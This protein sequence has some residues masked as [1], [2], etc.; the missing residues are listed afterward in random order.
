MMRY[1]CTKAFSIPECDDDGFI[2]EQEWIVEKG[3]VWELDDSGYSFIGGEVRLEAVEPT[4]GRWLE[5]TG[6][7]L[8]EYFEEVLGK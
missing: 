3:T 4:S 1:K 2:T 5:I 6:E 8:E 7:T